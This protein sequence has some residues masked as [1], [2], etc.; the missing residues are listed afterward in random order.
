[1]QRIARQRDYPFTEVREDEVAECAYMPGK[2][3][4]MKE[5]PWQVNPWTGE[6]DPWLTY[7]MP[8]L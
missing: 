3:S 8:G 6:P 1:M 2:D 5:N 4:P 7:R